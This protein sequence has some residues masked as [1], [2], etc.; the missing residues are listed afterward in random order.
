M[1][2][3]ITHWWVVLLRASRRNRFALS[4]HMSCGPRSPAKK[5][6]R[7]KARDLR[8]SPCNSQSLLHQ[9]SKTRAE[10]RSRLAPNYSYKKP[11]HPRMQQLET[12]SFLIGSR[13]PEKFR[14]AV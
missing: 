1:S 8:D 14:F 13:K 5:G 6:Q 12:G 9:D 7:S 11:L 4:E 10:Q 3:A 2:G